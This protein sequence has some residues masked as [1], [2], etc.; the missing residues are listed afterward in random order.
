VHVASGIALCTSAG[1]VVTD[2]RGR[3]VDTGVGGLVAA[4]DPETHASLV[5]IIDKQFAPGGGA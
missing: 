5:A 1:C 3:P 4:A 2:L